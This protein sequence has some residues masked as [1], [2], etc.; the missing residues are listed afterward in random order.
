MFPFPV[1]FTCKQL[2]LETLRGE[3]FLFGD[4]DSLHEMKFN[5]HER[6]QIELNIRKL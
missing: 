5:P 2:Q 4:S 3:E 6:G 1:I